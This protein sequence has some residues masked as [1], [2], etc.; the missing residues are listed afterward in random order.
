MSLNSNFCDSLEE[1]CVQHPITG[2]KIPLTSFINFP[3]YFL[4]FCVL[5]HLRQTGWDLG[6]FA[7]VLQYLDLDTPVW[8]TVWDYK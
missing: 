3:F 1:I 7:T 5:S 4:H 6:S 2:S 8:E